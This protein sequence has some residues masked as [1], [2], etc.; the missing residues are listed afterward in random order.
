VLRIVAG[1]GLIST[2]LWGL[3]CLID[4]SPRPWFFRRWL[5]NM[6]IVYGLFTMVFAA[7]GFNQ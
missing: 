1:C 2:G 4:R 5:G 6:S 3:T 7:L